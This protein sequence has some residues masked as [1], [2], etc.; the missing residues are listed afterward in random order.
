MTHE[1]KPFLHDAQLDRVDI[2]PLERT[3]RLHVRRYIT[4]ND[5]ERVMSV[6][7]FGNVESISGGINLADLAQHRPFGNVQDWEPATAPGVSYIH[8]VGGTLVVVGDAPTVVDGAV[9]RRD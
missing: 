9:A 1:E 8:F 3:L 4:M 5:R 6:I 2:D 7:A